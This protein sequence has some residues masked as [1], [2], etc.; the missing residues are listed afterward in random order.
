M[1]YEIS[2][3]SFKMYKICFI[4]LYKKTLLYSLQVKEGV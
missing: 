1:P 4:E 2:A 3:F